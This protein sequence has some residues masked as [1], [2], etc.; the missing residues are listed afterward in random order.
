M[1][2]WSMGGRCGRAVQVAPPTAPASKT[3]TPAPNLATSTFP[4]LQPREARHPAPPSQTRFHPPGP[5]HS[6]LHTPCVWFRAVYVQSLH[7]RLFTPREGG[8][9]ARAVCVWRGAVRVAACPLPPCLH[10]SPDP[11]SSQNRQSN[12]SRRS[13][14]TLHTSPC[15]HSSHWLRDWP[16]GASNSATQSGD[17][18]R[19]RQS[20]GTGGDTNDQTRRIVAFGENSGAGVGV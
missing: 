1:G 12:R 18:K 17:G 9:V 4:P 13:R 7:T 2:E 5:S 19:T 3:Q 10:N 15:L 14:P 20:H 8:G 16:S 6:A 11:H